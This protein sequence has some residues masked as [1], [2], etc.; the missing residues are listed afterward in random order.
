[1]DWK[2]VERIDPAPYAG[3]RYMTTR[4]RESLKRSIK[5]AGIVT[6]ILIRPDLVDGAVV[7][8]IVIDGHKRLEVARELG[9][10]RV[11]VR[12]IRADEHQ[13]SDLAILLHRVTGENRIAAIA[14]RV[15][16]RDHL[17]LGMTAREQ[18]AMKEHQEIIKILAGE[19]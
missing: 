6:P 19:G 18:G 11:P 3:D 16:G 12:E 5:Q 15:R 13:A 2:L 17:A 14:G 9:M 10:E 8:Y 7:R 4:D 1:M